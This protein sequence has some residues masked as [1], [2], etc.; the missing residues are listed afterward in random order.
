MNGQYIRK[1]DDDSYFEE[2]KKWIDVKNIKEDKLN[3]VL[4]SLKPRLVKMTDIQ[5][6]LKL[7]TQEK[8]KIV[9]EDAKKIISMNSTKVVLKLYIEK[10]NSANKLTANDFYKIMNEIQKETGVK[11]KNLWMPIRIALT[12]EMHGPELDYIVE[13]FGKEE[14][15]KRVKKHI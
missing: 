3:I 7:F 2:A 8:F 4:K 14:N 6:K 12:G 9:S 11:G 10:V 13:Y 15:I 5:E 1:L